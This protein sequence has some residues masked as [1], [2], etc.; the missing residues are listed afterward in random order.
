MT[1]AEA[2]EQRPLHVFDLGGVLVD[3]DFERFV[4]AVL[5]RDS[6]AEPARL[7]AFCAGPRKLALDRGRVTPLA[8]LDALVRE[9][10]PAAGPADSLL[11]AWTDIFLP[12]PRTA[13]VLGSLAARSELWLLSDT[14]PAHFA[15][16]LDDFPCVRGF[17]RFLLSYVRGMVKGEPGAFEPLVEQAHAGRRLRFYDDRPGNVDAARAAGLDAQ[18]FVGWDAWEPLS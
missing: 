7:R 11:D 14:D 15:R 2:G 17:H 6:G 12:V 8:F 9:L 3:V 16:I 13:E 5:A 10:A 18:L 4:Q 1:G